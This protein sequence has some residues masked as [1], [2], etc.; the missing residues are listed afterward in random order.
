MTN[1]VPRTNSEE[2]QLVFW[3]YGQLF[4]W[5]TFFFSQFNKNLFTLIL[6]PQAFG[7]WSL[8]FENGISVHDIKS[9]VPTHRYQWFSTQQ[10]PCESYVGLIPRAECGTPRRRLF[11]ADRHLWLELQVS[12]SPC[13]STIT[14]A[15]SWSLVNL[16]HLFSI[17]RFHLWTSFFSENS[18]VSR[19]NKLSAAPEIGRQLELP[20][21]ASKADLLFC[22]VWD[23][24][25]WM[26]S[27]PIHNPQ[28]TF[29]S[30][31]IGITM[32]HICH[33]FFWTDWEYRTH[34]CVQSI[35]RTL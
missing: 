8:L 31:V 35:W 28:T 20:A 3:Y 1:V 14:Q 17:S 15:V 7:P 12:E 27:S 34:L 29:Y 6:C 25:F 22:L 23:T 32:H 9:F 21:T 26:E 33:G 16:F 2:F 11:F 10:L 13:C 4:Y 19:V 30:E 24:Y 5:T 18:G